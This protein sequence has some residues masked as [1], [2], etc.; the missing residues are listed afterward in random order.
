MLLT[1]Y[2]PILEE[3]VKE[4]KQNNTNEKQY[5]EDAENYL[6]KKF[7]MWKQQFDIV[8][9]VQKNLRWQNRVLWRKHFRFDKKVYW[10]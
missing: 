10:L 8:V 4:C 9:K 6:K 1:K 2:Y 3:M 5:L 7:G